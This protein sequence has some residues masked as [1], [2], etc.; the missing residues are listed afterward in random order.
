MLT[1]IQFFFG[2][3]EL[4]DMVSIGDITSVS[5]D[6]RHKS[7]SDYFWKDTNLKSKISKGDSIFTGNNSSS[8]VTLKDGKLLKI[9]Q[10]SLVH[11]SMNKE[12]LQ[13]DLA[14]G[15]ISA[16]GLDKS[17]VITDCGQKYTIDA[18]KASFELSKTDKCGSFD[19]KVKTGTVK[20]NS[21]K[22]ISSLPKAK[23][24]SLAD[25]FESAP[26]P[27]LQIPVQDVP[28]VAEIVPEPV[29]TALSAP[30]FLQKNRIVT[31]KNTLK[32]KFTWKPVPDAKK[33]LLEIS[34]SSDF[35]KSTV[36]ET[37]S[38][39]FELKPDKAGLSY[40][41]M[42]ATAPEFLN[43][44]YSDIKIVKTKFPEI[45]VDRL[46]IEDS[47][48]A[49]SPA[50]V[51]TSKKFSVT[52]NSIPTA[53]SYFIEVSSYPDFSDSLKSSEAKPEAQL[54]VPQTGNYYYRISA[55]NKA[56]RKISSMPAI[57]EIIYKKINQVSGPFISAASK[58]LSYYFQKEYGQFIWLR[59]KARE[60]TSKYRLE[61]S[62]SSNFNKIN[63][64]FATA[65]TKYLIKS[66]IPEG[67]YF[68]RV[69]SET[70]TSNLQPSA[71][72]EIAILKI[73]TK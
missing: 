65:D 59:W 12:Q 53:K 63:F 38:T 51:G 45:I 48:N 18:A 10:N 52:W 26:A 17:M 24:I 27:K 8:E 67:E 11:F 70:L 22:V 29:K 42:Q 57:G 1:D 62:K 4:S 69:R 7:K 32:V 21:K 14:F 5:S 41:R 9:S 37:T 40:F 33:Y 28:V 13:V 55:L 25:T 68:W 19:I 23:K 35:Q 58:R 50:D 71:W 73:Q 6:V 31:L 34:S 64:S 43:S 54:M 36:V 16:S 30:Q 47:Y 2:S 72:S 44:D 3:N 46:R 20:I 60:Q 49:R 56:G 66:K 61:I 39:S 15:N